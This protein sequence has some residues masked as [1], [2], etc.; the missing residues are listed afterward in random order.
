MCV[1][2]TLLAIGFTC[3]YV[4]PIL[5][6]QLLILSVHS[7]RIRVYNAISNIV[8]FLCPTYKLDAIFEFST[9]YR[10]TE[11]TTYFLK[12]EPEGIV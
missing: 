8:K 6:I 10:I 3:I 2:L 9:G 1:V 7:Y 4:Q 5:C 12:V 11:E